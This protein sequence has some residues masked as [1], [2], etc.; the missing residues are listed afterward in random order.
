MRDIFLGV[1]GGTHTPS[2][3]SSRRTR[4]IDSYIPGMRCAVPPPPSLG[5]NQSTGSIGGSEF[6]PPTLERH[7]TTGGIVD[8]V[9]PPPP[10]LSR[11]ISAGRY[12]SFRRCL[13]ELQSHLQSHQH[14]FTQ[15]HPPPPKRIGKESP[16]HLGKSA[17]EDE[18]LDL[19][20]G[21]AYTA[22]PMSNS[23]LRKLHA[24]LAVWVE[25]TTEEK[26]YDI[27]PWNDIHHDPPLATNKTTIDYNP[28][29]TM[30]ESSP[31]HLADLDYLVGVASLKDGAV[32]GDPSNRRR[33]RTGKR[34]SSSK[35]NIKEDLDYDDDTYDTSSYCSSSSKSFFSNSSTCDKDSAMSVA[36]SSRQPRRNSLNSARTRN[37]TNSACTRNSATRKRENVSSRRNGSL[38]PDS[39]RKSHR[40]S[41]SC[42]V[43]TQETLTTAIP[44]AFPTWAGRFGE[45]DQED[46]SSMKPESFSKS[47]RR[48]AKDCSSL[49]FQEE[50]DL[51]SS[52]RRIQSCAPKMNYAHSSHSSGEVGGIYP[53]PTKPFGRE[54][55][56]G[57]HFKMTAVPTAVPMGNSAGYKPPLNTR[58]TIRGRIYQLS[59]LYSKRKVASPIDDQPVQALKNPPTLHDD[60]ATVKDGK[61]RPGLQRQKKMRDF[62]GWNEAEDPRRRG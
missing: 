53:T 26:D 15:Q 10:S 44:D 56:G 12:V 3:S 60:A 41:R 40:E 17:N 39:N 16:K 43:G 24:D 31:W 29:A 2:S 52:I 30:T 48:E 47:F 18:T 38:R 4:T 9:C 32:K 5:W 37:S 7:N 49:S 50:E 11:N 6:P 54:G 45:Q 28:T 35:R 42:R 8:E 1:G 58:R 62:V 55:G 20:E 23:H 19:P 14:K 57:V 22:F 34:R 61:S 33:S 27:T 36:S 51:P 13:L 46:N 25:E 59:R 21:H